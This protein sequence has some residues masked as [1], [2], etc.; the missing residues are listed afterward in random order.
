VLRR[1]LATPAPAGSD[2]EPAAAPGEHLAAICES[3]PTVAA[4][5][6]VQYR[7][8]HVA[9]GLSRLI[10]GPRGLGR[11]AG[12]RFARVLGSGHDGG[13][14]LRPDFARQ[15]LMAFFDDAASAN[16]FVDRDPQVDARRA[17]AD[18]T[19]IAVLRPTATRGCWGGQA[20]AV[21][22]TAAADRPIA[23]LTRASIRVRH[24]ATF[25]RHSPPAEASLRAADGCRLAVGLGE[26]PVLRQAT[27]SVWN[28]AG[29]MEAWARSGAHRHAAA[30]AWREHWFHEWMFV[31]FA[32]DRLEGRWRGQVH[33]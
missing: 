19:L 33:G 25:W 21:G 29:A 26:A 20:L 31:R 7:P 23:S 18:E 1:A 28:S 30:G 11:P 13:F 27:F 9:W 16:A 24:A 3:L 22:A 17:R 8:R 15:G 12:L 14:G 2:P 6:L 10:A 4:L 5:M 32:I